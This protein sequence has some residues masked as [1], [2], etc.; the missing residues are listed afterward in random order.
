M[1][2]FLSIVLSVGLTILC[3]AQTENHS[4]LSIREIMRGEEYVGYLP[5]NPWWSEDGESIYF[6]WNPDFDTLRSTYK[7]DVSSRKISKLT[8]EELKNL[9][10]KGG[11]YNSDHSEK[12]YVK[13]GDIFLMDVKNGQIFQVTNTTERAS[14]PQF[15]RDEKLII[16]QS[17]NNLFSWDIQNG[18]VAQLTNFVSGNE[19]IES[20]PDEMHQWLEQDQ[21]AYFDILRKQK[22]KKDAQERRSE[23]QD[24]PRPRK[25][26]LEKSNWLRWWPIQH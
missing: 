17:A 21:L 26:S 9:P 4:A 7:I 23:Q 13:N 11:D 22:Y 8:F 25:F 18:A 14:N 15:S 16:Y 19:K 12:V 2:Y 6:S 10:S 24:P 3:Q 5:E 1:K 20:I